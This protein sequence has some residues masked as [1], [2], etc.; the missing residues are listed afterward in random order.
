MKQEDLDE[1]YIEESINKILADPGVRI[2]YIEI[3]SAIKNGFY[4]GLKYERERNKKLDKTT[5]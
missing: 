4:M 3:I 1:A 2:N 5:K